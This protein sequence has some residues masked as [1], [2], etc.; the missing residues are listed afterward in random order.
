VQLESFLE[1]SARLCPDK[2]ALICGRSRWT[3]ADLEAAANRMAHALLSE[4]VQRGDR[5]AV[6]LENGFDAVAAIFAVLKAGAVFMMVN[7]TAKADKLRF[8]LNNSRAAVLVASA[9]KLLALDETRALTPHLRLAIATGE[10]ARCDLPGRRCLG[11]DEIL[12]H[13]AGND[14]PPP[15]RAIDVDLAALLY[16]S[17]TTGNP[18]GVMLSHLNM[19][20]VADSITT[21]LENTAD[22][23][24]LNVLPLSFGYGLCQVFT[25]AKIGGTVVLERSFAYPHA[26]LQKLVQERVTGFP[27]VPTMA[28]ILLQMDLAKYDWSSLRYVTNAG[29]ALPTEHIV[30]LGRLL[31]RTR[32]YSMYG[33]TECLRVSYLPP[34]ELD[35]RPN[36]V[37]RGM[38]NEEVYVV[39]EEGHRVAPGVAGELV[40]RGS[41][42]MN[43]YWE[44]PEETA[45]RLRPGPL[46]SERVLY[47]GDLFRTDE[48]GF[49][50]FVGR[51]DDIIKS[52][53]EK[54]SP[55]EVENALCSHAEIA[56]AAVV[57]VPDEILGQAI[58]AVVVLKNGSRLT[59]RDVL[60]H[61]ASRLE[62][63]MVP[64]LVEFRSS[65]PKTPN[66]KIDKKAL[67]SSPASQ[68]DLVPATRERGPAA[69]C[70]P[71]TDL[72]G[73]TSPLCHPGPT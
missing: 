36:S 18:K 25:A 53:G 61:C 2:T 73:S 52:R 19:V 63:F 35:R 29:A 4:G 3:Y 45:R 21:Y 41:N 43:G 13:G 7:P 8:V 30:R 40:V 68:M 26:V 60:R 72:Q 5:V 71:L 17:G 64:K 69:P 46:P 34:E 11:F 6:Y 12:K 65:L 23:V 9:S 44:L 31:P 10:S 39:D 58:K 49:L 48:E 38:P 1:S 32:I 33:L 24:I 54:V 14:R 37:G 16:T 28:A 51:K 15:K 50:Y 42:V 20:S 47:T 59:G 27:F 22:D 62:D 57:G 67:M 55:K 70:L 66:G 56:E